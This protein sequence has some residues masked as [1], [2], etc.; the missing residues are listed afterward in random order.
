MSKGLENLSSE[1]RLKELHHVTPERRKFGDTSS[2]Y[3]RM[4]RTATKR[5]EEKTIHKG[6]KLRGERFHL[7]ITEKFFSDNCHSLQ[8]H[9]WGHGRVPNTRGFQEDLI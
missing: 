4:E 3:P 5:T 1:E 6:Y 9:S 7:N 8:H 2:Q